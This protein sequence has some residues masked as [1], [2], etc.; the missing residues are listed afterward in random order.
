MI[1]TRYMT[2]SNLTILSSFLIFKVGIIAIYEDSIFE[3]T[4]DVWHTVGTQ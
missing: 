1:L 4:L 2:L 3:D